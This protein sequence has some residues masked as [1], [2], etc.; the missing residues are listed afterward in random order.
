MKD[1]TKII[2]SLNVSQMLLISEV[3][4]AGKLI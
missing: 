1:T 2:S 3:L 4:K